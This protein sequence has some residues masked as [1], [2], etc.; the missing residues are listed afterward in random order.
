MSDFD[1]YSL[2]ELK[3]VYQLLHQQLPDHMELMDGAFL[4]D[5][6]TQLQQSAKKAGVDV[7]LHAEWAAWLEQ[8]P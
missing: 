3:L 4:H 2:P 1:D 7:S 5:L 6:Q 8:R